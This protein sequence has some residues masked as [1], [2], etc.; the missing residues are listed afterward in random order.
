MECNVMK[1]IWNLYIP[2]CEHTHTHVKR[3]LQSVFSGK[4]WHIH[5]GVLSQYRLYRHNAVRAK[6][7][8]SAG[9]SVVSR[10]HIPHRTIRPHRALLAARNA[11]PPIDKEAVGQSV[12][13]GNWWYNTCAG[14]YAKKGFPQCRSIG[15]KSLLYPIHAVHARR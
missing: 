9:C 1:K 4:M 12:F 7:S 14:G 5:V 15:S 2:T 11:R 8:R 13:S 3:S 6:A 10:V